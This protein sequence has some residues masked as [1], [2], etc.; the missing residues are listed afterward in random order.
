MTNS[1]EID[2]DGNGEHADAVVCV[3]LTQPL[4]MPDNVIGLCAECGEAIQHRPHVPKQ[5]RK[6]CMECALPLASKAAKKGELHTILTPQTAAEVGAY[7]RKK[8][9]H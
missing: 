4:I 7:F 1:V 9:A 5:P 6:I 8:G 2:D 3:R